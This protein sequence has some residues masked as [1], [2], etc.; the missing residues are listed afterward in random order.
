MFIPRTS[1]MLVCAWLSRLAPSPTENE[2]NIQGRCF[3]KSLAMARRCAFRFDHS[4]SGLTAKNG[5]LRGFSVAAADEKYVPAEA[6]IE[7]E[8]GGGLG[9]LN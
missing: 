8:Y 2:S 9:R 6:K 7:G 5:A 3:A 4:Q 1:R